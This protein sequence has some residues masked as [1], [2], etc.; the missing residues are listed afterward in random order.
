MGAQRASREEWVRR[1][2]SWRR[3]GETANVFAARY[4]WNPGNLRWWSSEERRSRGDSVAFVEVTAAEP[5]RTKSCID[6][7]LANGRRLRVRG[8]VDAETVARLAR[9]LEA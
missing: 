4:G 1:V 8:D 2:A 7:L 3:S 9:A 5:L 6:V